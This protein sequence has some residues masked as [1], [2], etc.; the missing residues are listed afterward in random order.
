NG[1]KQGAP[2][3]PEGL[4]AM[5]PSKERQGAQKGW[6]QWR[7]SKERQGAQKG[8]RQWRPIGRFRA[9]QLFAGS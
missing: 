1:A 2:G 7:P 9:R 3:S 8:W 5:E 4:E 6:R